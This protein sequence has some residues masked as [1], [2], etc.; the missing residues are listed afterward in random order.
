MVDPVA[1]GSLV[2]ATLAALRPEIQSRLNRRSLEILT[3]DSSRPELGY[4][5]LGPSIGLLGTFY[6]RK[7]KTFIEKFRLRV[8]REIDN[9]EFV[10]SPL[11]NRE[12]AVI[13][14]AGGE[15][16]R[17]VLWSPPLMDADTAIAF[18]VA[19]RDESAGILL[20]GAYATLETDWRQ[21]IVP[22][23]VQNAQ[24]LAA[25]T[26][27][28]SRLRLQ[29][30]Q[31]GRYAAT[32]NEEF[33]RRAHRVFADNFPWIA[34]RYACSLEVEPYDDK[35]TFSRGFAFTLTQQQEQDLR[36]AID[37]MSLRAC[38]L[39]DATVPHNFAYPEYEPVDN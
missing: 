16:L 5:A 23:I 8:V 4:G 1:V 25:A 34:G 3:Q 36:Q 37:Q 28:A 32:A 30:F 27:E 11:L 12:R 13:D 35:R 29:Q 24:L 2:V 6:N 21:Y 7:K 15:S 19:F 17:G 20:S 18:D 26:P 31:Q 33:R 39:V 22:E 38:G 14:R 9:T 10:F